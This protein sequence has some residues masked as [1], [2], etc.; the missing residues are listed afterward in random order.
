M[1]TA[2]VSSRLA[3]AVALPSAAA[4]VIVAADGR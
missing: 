2:F 1:L 4:T 3:D